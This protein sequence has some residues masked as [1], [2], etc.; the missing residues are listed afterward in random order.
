MKQTQ[1]QHSQRAIC[2]RKHVDMITE[3][4]LLCCR[5]HAIACVNQ[6]II[7]RTQALMLHIDPFI[8]ASQ[9]SNAATRIC[10]SSQRL[11]ALD[12]S[13]PTQSIYTHSQAVWKI[14]LRYMTMTFPSQ[15]TIRR[16]C[17]ITYQ[18]AALRW[19][20]ILFTAEI[21]THPLLQTTNISLL[22]TLIASGKGFTLVEVGVHKQGQ[23][24]KKLVFLLVFAC[25]SEEI[26]V[27]FTVDKKC[28]I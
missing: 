16:P 21:H 23:V 13:V 11:S 1:R 22:H 8:E 20:V 27:A 17:F 7:S 2:E 26:F 12:L 14:K 4:L 28:L 9:D 24:I 18:L 19:F 3:W 15:G 6:F 25:A 10:T 5:S